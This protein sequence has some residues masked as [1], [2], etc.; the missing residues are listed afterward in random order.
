MKSL[1][2]HRT[3]RGRETKS[4]KSIPASIK[5]LVTGTTGGKG[6]ESVNEFF[7]G[8]VGENQ[9]E[10]HFRKM[11]GAKCQAEDSEEE[12]MPVCSTLF[13]FYICHALPQ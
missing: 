8:G 3:K 12:E 2:F 4:Y 9:S 7:G 1:L 5:I 6:D 13:I 10:T 11:V